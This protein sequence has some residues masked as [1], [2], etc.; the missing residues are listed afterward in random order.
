MKVNCPPAGSLPPLKSVSSVRHT[1]PPIPFVCAAAGTSERYDAAAA[2][3]ITCDVIDELTAFVTVSDT[4]KEPCV[5][6]EW[7]GFCALDVEPSPKL[8]SHDAGEPVERSVKVTLA[9]T[10]GDAGVMSKAAE[11]GCVPGVAVVTVMVWDAT[12]VRPAA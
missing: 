9:P 1:V 12:D 8:H 3:V 6:Y 11:T 7:I 5:A 2:T 4:A 10:P